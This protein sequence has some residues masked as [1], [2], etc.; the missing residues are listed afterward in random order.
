M[1]WARVVTGAVGVAVP[2]LRDT[3]LAELKAEVAS[4]KRAVDLRAV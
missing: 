3:E 1:G 2:L 4:L